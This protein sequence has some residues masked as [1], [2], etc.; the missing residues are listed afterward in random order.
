MKGEGEEAD[1]GSRALDSMN[2]K[3]Y[4]ITLKQKARAFFYST[5]RWYTKEIHGQAQFWSLVS[6]PI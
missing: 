3:S 5:A 4:G 1:A 2:G 6:C